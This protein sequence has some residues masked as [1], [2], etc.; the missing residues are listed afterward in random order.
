MAKRLVAKVDTYKDR[1]GNDKG[2]YV[3]IGVILSNDNGEY[4]L[5]NPDVNL[6]GVLMKQRV[7]LPK[8]GKGD[9][10]MCGIFDN[11]QQGQQQAPQQ[12]PQQNSGGNGGGMDG[13]GGNETQSGSANV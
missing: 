6:A 5:I 3:E 2:K 7:N 11:S 4:A 13:F 10:V 8:G 1:E 12:A 9:M